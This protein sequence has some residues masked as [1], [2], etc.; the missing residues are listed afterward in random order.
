MMVLFYENAAKILCS[1]IS[2]RIYLKM[3]RYLVMLLPLILFAAPSHAK[4][5]EYKLNVSEKTVNISG[6][7]AIVLVL[8]N[9]IPRP[10]FKATVGDTMRV[11]VKNNLDL[12]SSIHWHSVLVPN[13][14]DG[15]PY[16]NG[17]PIKRGETFTYEFPIKHSGT[18]WYHAHSAL[19]EQQGI[20]GSLIFSQN[21]VKDYD[22]EH[23]LVLSDWT[24]EN[25]D[26]VL[27]NLKKDP[28]YYAL[29]K[30]FVQSWSK[31]IKNGTDAI[32]IRINN[33]WMRMRPMDMS[34]IG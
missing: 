28:D 9:A 13:N 12:D 15:V 31:V 14:M 24:D 5:I 3:L 34:D 6:K 10:T 18:Y 32:K 2:K 26:H 8:N 4:V 33:A 27:S 1:V 19:Q 21:E 17:P 25:P 22:E 7:E 11:E 20:Y 23:V 29:K 30:D 16:V